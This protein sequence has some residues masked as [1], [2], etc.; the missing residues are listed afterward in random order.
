MGKTL[1]EL[2][3]GSPQDKSVKSD[4]ETLVEQELTG[5]RTKSA[6]ELNNPLIYGNEATRIAQRSTPDLEDMKEGTGGEAGDG[7]LIGKGLGK[8]TKGKLTSIGD[9]RDKVNSKLGIP[10][11]QIPTRV[12]DE[13]KDKDSQTPVVKGEDGTEVGKLLKESAGNP[14]TI[15]KHL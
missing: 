5:V 12:I 14:K 9:V 2:F 8:L 1:L 4:K 7:G 11:N 3:K 6:V 13:I 10:V 15:L